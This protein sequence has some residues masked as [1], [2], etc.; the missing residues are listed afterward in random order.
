M[1]NEKYIIDHIYKKVGIHM[2]LTH[3]FNDSEIS[4]KAKGLLAYMYENPNSC[5]IESLLPLANDGITSLQNGLKELTVK[6]Y[7]H[8]FPERDKLG[9]IIRFVY[10]VRFQRRVPG[11]AAEKD[12]I[13]ATMNQSNWVEERDDELIRR[14]IS[15]IKEKNDDSYKMILSEVNEL[16]ELGHDKGRI[17]KKLL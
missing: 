10:K 8:T 17:V 1:V 4:W 7:Y 9:K 11:I 12:I 5:N 15:I 16:Y 3:Y 13:Q 6:G 14:A 2:R